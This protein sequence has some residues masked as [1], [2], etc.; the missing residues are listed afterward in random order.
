MML[1]NVFRYTPLS[2]IST[3]LLLGLSTIGHLIF[4]SKPSIFSKNLKTWYF[5]GIVTMLISMTSGTLIYNQSLISG[6]IANLQFYN[7]G[8]VMLLVYLVLKSKISF[9]RIFSLLNS[10]GWVVLV[11]IALMAITNFSFINESQ[12][13]GEILVVHA[14]KVSK[15][16]T[17]FIALYCLAAFMFKS[18]YKYLLYTILFF[19]A[20]HFYDLQRFMIL[21]NL[22][23]IA[24]AVFKMRKSK[25]S[26]KF[27]LPLFFCIAFLSIYIF[28]S[29]KGAS[30]VGDFAQT[31]EL[32]SEDSNAITDN[33]VSA[34]VHEID[35]AL[36]KFTQYPLFGNGYYRA[37]EGGKVIGEGIHFYVSDIGIIGILFNL[38]IFGIVLF[39]KQT[40]LVWKLLMSKQNNQYQFLMVLA[41]IF[42]L[43]LSLVTGSSIKHYDYFFLLIAMLQ[44]STHSITIINDKM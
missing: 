22:L 2:K 8:S 31:F 10:V 40:K 28:N 38:G 39:L 9:I 35:L 29:T 41:L 23:L 13:T 36:T 42:L 21:I 6:I 25:A 43:S 16:L 37:S 26:L 17:N 3:Y 27:I 24:T 18:N 5:I 44:L 30:I 34:R 33:S 12:L 32:F 4:I 20:N 19:S 11:L 15:N 7:I 14:G 1:F